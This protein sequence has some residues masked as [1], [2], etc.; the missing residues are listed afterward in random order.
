MKRHDVPQRGGDAVGLRLAERLRRIK[1]SAS[2]ATVRTYEFS[3]CEDPTRPT[4][5]FS[6]STQRTRLLAVTTCDRESELGGKC[7]PPT[8]FKYSSD[9]DGADPWSRN[10]IEIEDTVHPSFQPTNPLFFADVNTATPGTTC[11]SG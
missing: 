2:G 10:P 6:P 8:K 9:A 7:L 4:T 3:Y 1:V 5:C 11:S